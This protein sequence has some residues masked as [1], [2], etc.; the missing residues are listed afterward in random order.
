VI[1]ILGQSL[2]YWTYF[3][4]AFG[5]VRLFNIG[6][7]LSVP[8][9][10]SIILLLILAILLGLIS[11]HQARINGV[12]IKHWT[13]LTILTF[14]LSVN[15]GSHVHNLL[16]RPVVSLLKTYIDFFPFSRLNVTILL[17]VLI[18][19]FFFRR[20]Y[21]SLPKKT[22]SRLLIATLVYL[23]G[24]SILTVDPGFFASSEE[25]VH[26]IFI[27]FGKFL[28]LSG[29]VL[30]IGA[31]LDY[32]NRAYNSISLDFNDMNGENK[33]TTSP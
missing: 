8:T 10:Y 26:I 27:S 6:L 2:K 32:I 25:F 13:F 33:A 1:S 17:L 20:F 4:N 31:C 23:A 22:R 7:T 3:E 29:M 30:L 24:F 21:L 16:I 11:A 19:L 15:R 12:F 28:E 9:I 14:Y 18:F 5:L